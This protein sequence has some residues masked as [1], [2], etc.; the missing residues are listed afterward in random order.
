MT[1]HYSL[2]VFR[3]YTADVIFEKIDIGTCFRI[4]DDK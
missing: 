3:G 4:V 1:Y 2:I